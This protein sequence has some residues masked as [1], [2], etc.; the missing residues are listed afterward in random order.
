M[1]VIIKQELEAPCKWR[2]RK[3]AATNLQ[4]SQYCPTHWEPAQCTAVGVD[5]DG[6]MS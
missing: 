1:I 3:Q 5:W 6:K 4:I 2:T